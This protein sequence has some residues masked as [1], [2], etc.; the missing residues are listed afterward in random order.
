MSVS[1]RN[2]MFIINWGV[3]QF[4]SSLLS[5]QEASNLLEPKNSI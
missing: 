3:V 1:D 2:Y 5:S 4:K